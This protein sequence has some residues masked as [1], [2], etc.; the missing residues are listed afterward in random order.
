MTPSVGRTVHYAS[1]DL[2]EPCRAAVITSV[3]R[4]GV[5]ALTKTVSLCVMNPTGNEFIQCSPFDGSPKPFAGSW[6][7]P[8]YVVS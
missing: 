2:D 4:E 1:F 6:H 8:E 3:E 5:G 7:W